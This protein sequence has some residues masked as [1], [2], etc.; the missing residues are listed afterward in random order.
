M[1]A[2]YDYGAG[3]LRS[4]ANTLEA[5]GAPYVIVREPGGLARA[6]KVILPGVGH[7]GQIMRALD[8]KGVRRA[9]VEVIGSG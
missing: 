4:V 1:I 6:S 9:I 3:N 7:Y 8:A 5:I 2:I